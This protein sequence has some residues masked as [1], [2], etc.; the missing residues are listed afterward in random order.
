MTTRLILFAM[1]LLTAAKNAPPENWRQQWKVPVKGTKLY[2][3]NLG[4]PF[5]VNADELIKFRDDGSVFRLYSNKSLGAITSVDVSNPLKILLFYKDFS[6][7]VFLDNTLSANGNP[8][9]LDEYGLEQASQVCTSYD[10]GFWVFEPVHYRLIRFNQHL[11]ETTRVLN[12]NQLTGSAL[13]PAFMLEHENK[14]Y[15]SDPERGILQFDIF[16]TY[17]KTIPLKGIKKFRVAGDAIFYTN[18]HGALNSF[19]LKTLTKSQL[20]LPIKDYADWEFGK[21]RLLLL[22]ADS[23]FLYRIPQR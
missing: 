10:N 11:Q 21:D 14:L 20:D 8:I 9:Y 2:A 1:L 19:G 13:R 16:G 12:L 6:R 22:S 3:D 15:M 23:L 5:V 4:N 7:I 17:I 18:G